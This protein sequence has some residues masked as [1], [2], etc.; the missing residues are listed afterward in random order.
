MRRR[1]SKRIR[2]RR[3]KRKRRKKKTM[4]VE[5]KGR[6]KFEIEYK[7]GGESGRFQSGRQSGRENYLRRGRRGGKGERVC[8]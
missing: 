2:I 7:F 5:K 6:G 3:R 8:G 4:N 1:R